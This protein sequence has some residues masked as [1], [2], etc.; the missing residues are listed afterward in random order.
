M[1]KLIKPSDW[2]LLALAGLLDFIQDIK[3]PFDLF[4]NYYQDVYG[5]VPSRWQK[6]NFSHLIWRNVKI[7]NINKKVV[8][9]KV[10][11]EITSRGEKT[12][13]EKYPLLDLV[14]QAWD[15]KIR[16]AIYDI[17]E[18]NKRVRELFRR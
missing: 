5:A 11:L 10:Y 8:K 3:D 18:E 7:G 4:K 12:V 15:G 16:F 17:E 9:G 14:N 2:L 6:V 1:K 13:R